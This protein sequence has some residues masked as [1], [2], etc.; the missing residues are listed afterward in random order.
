M[1]NETKQIQLIDQAIEALLKKKRALCM[2][3]FN[4]M[5]AHILNKIG[6]R[7]EAT[8][9]GSLK[10]K[11]MSWYCVDG[12]AIKPDKDNLVIGVHIKYRS[13]TWSKYGAGGGF[14]I[15]GEAST[16][17]TPIRL[18][19]EYSKRLEYALARGGKPITKAEFNIMWDRCNTP[20][21]RACSVYTP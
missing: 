9:T 12:I 5:H 11:G 21:S 18:D 15:R 17:I 8:R 1:K 4:T 2:N 7:P 13:L 19:R 6:L 20:D 10:H 3:G 14:E 16:T